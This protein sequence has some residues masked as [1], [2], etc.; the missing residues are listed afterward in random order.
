MHFTAADW[1]LITPTSTIKNCFENCGFPNDHVSSNNNALTASE[2]N[3]RCSLTA[4]DVQLE[5]YTTHNSA[6]KV[7][8]V[9]I[10]KPVFDQQLSRT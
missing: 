5:D 7:C 2:E 8:G 10:L 9:H 4:L 1:K 6:L 3:D